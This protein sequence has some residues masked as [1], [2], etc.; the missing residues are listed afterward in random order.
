MKR[1]VIRY[2]TKPE[3]SDENRKLVEAVFAEL[4]AK[5][6]DGLRYL[7][8]RLADD[9]FVHFVE[10]EEG[11]GSRLAEQEAFRAFQAE[12]RDRCVEPPHPEE[13]VI[14]GNYGM[15]ADRDD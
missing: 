8:L 5:S 3:R 4:H 15:L 7:A 2:R 12:I 13:A 6:P 10:I 14:V 1:T 11:A 9:T